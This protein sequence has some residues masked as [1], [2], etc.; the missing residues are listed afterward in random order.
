MLHGHQRQPP[1]PPSWR[2]NSADFPDLFCRFVG[3]LNFAVFVLPICWV[4]EFRRFVLP[5]C[6]GSVILQIRS[7]DLLGL[8]GL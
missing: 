7:A 1:F 8:L 6:G 3:F 2:P 4:S 5:I